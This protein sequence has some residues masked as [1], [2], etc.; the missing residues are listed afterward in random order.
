M[1]F[2]VVLILYVEIIYDTLFGY[3]IVILPILVVIRQQRIMHFGNAFA[4]TVECI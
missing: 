4:G 2:V 3:F 1:F